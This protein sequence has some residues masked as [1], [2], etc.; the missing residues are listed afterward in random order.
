MIFMLDGLAAVAL[1]EGDRTAAVQ[2]I[3]R[4]YHIALA[5][6]GPE[7]PNTNRALAGLANMTF[8]SARTSTRWT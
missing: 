5:I 7:H 2:H 3:A 4:A 6:L 8:K 1:Q